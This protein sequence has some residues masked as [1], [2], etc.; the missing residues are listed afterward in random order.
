[1]I[2]LYRQRV[3]RLELNVSLSRSKTGQGATTAALGKVV[4]PGYHVDS[5]RNDPGNCLSN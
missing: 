1:M 3:A 5:E 4:A 2:M